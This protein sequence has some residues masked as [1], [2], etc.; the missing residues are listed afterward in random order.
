MA[1]S[2]MLISCGHNPSQVTA[3]LDRI[4]GE[5]TSTRIATQV[6]KSLT[7]DGKEVFV[8]STKRGKPFIQGSS[9]SALTTGIGT[10]TPS[11]RH[12]PKT[13]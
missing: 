4:G 8:I 12:P 13:P 2:L 5:G 3:L 6:K 7:T 1:A 11:P 9:V 10:A